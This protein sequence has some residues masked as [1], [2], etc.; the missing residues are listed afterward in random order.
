MNSAPGQTPDFFGSS[1]GQGNELL[2]YV[3]SMEPETVAHLSRP[4]SRDVLQMME[5]NVVGLL[6]GLPSQHFDVTVTTNR[7][8]LGKLLASAMMSGY[9]LRSAEQRMTFEQSLADTD[10]FSLDNAQEDNA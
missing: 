5:Q 3:Q 1:A 9:F 8:S 4:V 10:I 7:E 2:Q 6:G